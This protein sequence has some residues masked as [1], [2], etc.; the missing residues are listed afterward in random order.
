M[1]KILPIIIIVVIVGAG[2]F[3]GGMKYGQSKKVSSAQQ[4]FGQMGANGTGGL[5]TGVTGGTRNGAGGF[6][7]GEIIAKDDKS[8]TVKLQNGGSQIIFY[9]GTTE[10]G[11]TVTGTATDL[12]VGKTVTVTGQTNSDGSIT[13]QTIQIRPQISN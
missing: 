12:G 7:G 8:I 1:R 4:R 2:A 9:S 13:A 10:I 3:F 11:K 6:V 5:R